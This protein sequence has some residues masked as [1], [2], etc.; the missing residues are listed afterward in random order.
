LTIAAVSSLI[1]VDP[2]KP[3]PLALPPKQCLLAPPP[4]KRPDQV[5]KVGFSRLKQLFRSPEAH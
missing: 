3:L 2:C 1:T 5:G 4:S